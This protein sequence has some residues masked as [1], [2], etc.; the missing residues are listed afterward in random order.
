MLADTGETKL[1][2]HNN[3]FHTEIKPAEKSNSGHHWYAANGNPIPNLGVQSVVGTSTNNK[4]I[5]TDFNIGDNSI[6][7]AS[8]CQLINTNNK[9]VFDQDD[10]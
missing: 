3:V 1:V 5:G 8:I 6:P 10:S 7:I 2:A 9:A 4:H